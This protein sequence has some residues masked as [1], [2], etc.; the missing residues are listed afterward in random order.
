MCVGGVIVDDGR[1]LLTQRAASPQRG[2][3]SIP[4]G[5]VEHGERLTDALVREVREETGLAV[6]PGRFLGWVE[7]IAPEAHFVILDF[8]A[9]VEGGI[10]EAGDDAARAAWI[11]LA[12]LVTID[13]VDGLLSFLREVGIAPA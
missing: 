8:A 1:L 5:R 2:R 9:V 6:A 13:L 11:P 4:G 3:W 7:R 12:E 10:L